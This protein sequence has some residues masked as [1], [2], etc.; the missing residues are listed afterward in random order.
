MNL[1]EVLQLDQL[2][3]FVIIMFLML[4]L[5]RLCERMKL[6]GLIGLLLSGFI[7]GPKALDIL[8]AEQ[9]VLKFLSSVGKL[10]VMFFAG[11]EIDLGQ[12]S[13][14]WKRSMTFGSLTFFFPLATGCAIA[15]AAGQPLVSAVLIGSLLASHT[16]VGFVIVQKKGLLQ[17]RAVTSSIGATIFTDIAALTVLSL[18]I[19]IFTTGF[20]PQQL[21]LQMLGMLI[22]FPVVLIGGRFLAQKLLA[23]MKDN[24]EHRTLLMIFIMVFAAVIAELIHLEGIIGAFI[25]G[26]A[27]GGVLRGCKTKEKLETLGNTLFIPMFFLTVG[28]LID[29]LSF[30]RMHTPDLIFALSIVGGLVGAKAAAAF[31]SA[32]LLHFTRAEGAMMW[33]LS[34]PQVAATL[35]AALVAY[36]TVNSAGE[37]LISEV[38][39]DIALLLLAVTTI[40]GPILTEKFST[41]I[42]NEDQ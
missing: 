1:A 25:A 5:P 34:I 31:I 37:R 15:L 23:H 30:T 4:I 14:H 13:K 40:L 9:D 6:P 21:G 42:R 24:D 36:E 29:P 35:A 17:N 16:L 26:L 28:T 19:S 27:V 33:S 38:V 39:F 20:D 11:L 32:K 7:L 22:Y 41:K 3:G 8:H 2:S 18:C 12:F 10:M